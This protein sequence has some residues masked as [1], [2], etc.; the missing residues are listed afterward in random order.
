MPDKK[1]REARDA[2]RISKS[3]KDIISVET[4]GK[5]NP[6]YY[7][8]SGGISQLERDARESE[9]EL[10]RKVAMA[11]KIKKAMDHGL[12][13]PEQAH[14]EKVKAGLVATDGRGQSINLTEGPQGSPA[15]N[16]LVQEIAQEGDDERRIQMIGQLA[17]IEAAMKQTGSSTLTIPTLPR[18]EKRP[19]DTKDAVFN[20]LLEKLVDNV[21]KEPEKYDKVKD[22]GS[23]LEMMKN[24]NDMISPSEGADDILENIKKY[25]DAGFI[26]NEATSIEEKKL[27]LEKEK[28]N[29]EYDFKKM[30]MDSEGKRTENLMKIGT[31]VASSLLESIVDVKG[32]KGAQPESRVDDSQ[33]ARDNLSKASSA[34]DMFQAPCVK[35]KSNIEVTNVNEARNLKCPGCGQPYFLDSKNKQ[36]LMIEDS[37]PAAPQPSAPQNGLQKVESPKE[38]PKAPPVLTRGSKPI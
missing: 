32:R 7:G 35:C 24:Y 15:Y 21:T 16:L 38:V 31:D 36:L 25:R 17:N 9:K 29:H 34:V 20:K 12:L 8:G 33:F 3:Y 6:Y 19:D 30:Q 22:F 26:K 18:R 10:D 27:D 14:Q 5:G 23:M 37:E 11:A 4:G 28:I 2:A 1:T 13:T